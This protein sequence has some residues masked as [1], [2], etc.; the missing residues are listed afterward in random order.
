MA[1]EHELI[2]CTCDLAIPQKKNENKKTERKHQTGLSWSN[3]ATVQVVEDPRHSLVVHRCNLLPLGHLLLG[4]L[5][6]ASFLLQFPLCTDPQ[7]CPTISPLYSHALAQISSAN[8]V[9][10]KLGPNSCWKEISRPSSLKIQF[11]NSAPII[12][13]TP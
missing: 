11:R 2:S 10:V 4:T 1:N 3:L 9:I 8:L 13:S 12:L 6:L 7:C 5:G